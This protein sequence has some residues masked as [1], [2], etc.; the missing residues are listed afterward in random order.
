MGLTRRLEQLAGD[1]AVPVLVIAGGDTR[2][3]AQD[4]R[5][6][7]ELHILDTPKASSILI[8][9]GS[10]AEAH[11]P[12][13]ARIHDALPHPRATI[14]WASNGPAPSM[15]GA[16]DAVVVTGDPIAR[17]ISTYRDLLSGRRPSEPAILPDVDPAVW[18][19]VGPYGQGGSGMT[20]GTPYGR[21]MV[22]V[23]PDPDGLRLDVLPVSIGP[24]FPR[25]PAGL[26]LDVRFSGDLVLEA[27]VGAH[28]AGSGAMPPRPDLQP[29]LR[30]LAEP[31]LVRELELAR[32]REHLRWVAD[33][34]V[35]LGLAAL[36]S[37][38][39]RLAQRVQPG[40]GDS[41]RRFARL[42]GATRATGWST[43]GV[44]HLSASDLDGLGAGPVARAAGLPDDLRLEDPVYRDLGFRPV[45]AEHGD[46][47]A[48]WGVRLAEAAAALD[49][50]AR[51]GD[52]Q[53][54]PTGRIES[55]R[56]RLEPGSS[57][58]DRLLGL[59]PH[60]TQE[61]EWGD[62]LTALVSLDLDLDEGTHVERLARVVPAA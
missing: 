19:G 18:R 59:V 1:A 41:V 7:P 50:A 22:E 11:A 30:A 44:G 20:G 60:L 56:G 28:R 12:A 37:R 24:F 31:V 35:T 16:V 45:L 9:T 61:V 26:I 34:L 25:L 15:N 49:L 5:L 62:A 57:P 47:A 13:I 51:A 8:V 46:A 58:S 3:I 17:V 32:A 4:L 14:L 36:G 53:T 29:F 48:R 33:A 52:A 43:R 10:V 21:P 40:D 55:P 2:D 38:A 6:R 54:L 27:V 39:I 42:I 23:A